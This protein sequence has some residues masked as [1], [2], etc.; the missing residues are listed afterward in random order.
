MLRSVAL[1]RI[2]VSEDCSASF[3]RVTRIRELGT[4][5]AVTSNRRTLLR[6]TITTLKN[7]VFWVVTPCGSGKNRRF[8]GIWR[9]LHQG[10]K[11]RWTRNNTSLQEPHGV[12]TQKT[13]FFIVTAVKTSNLTEYNFVFV[14]PQG[15]DS[16]K[17]IFMK[18]L[19]K[20]MEQKVATHTHIYIYI[21]IYKPTICTDVI[22]RKLKIL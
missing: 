12:T 21:Y 10:D 16:Y 13:P 14:K 4:T 2:D 20:D 3:I 8:G 22:R 7:G 5:L 18:I 9:L 1:V 11:N 15:A 17:R 6:N 19:A